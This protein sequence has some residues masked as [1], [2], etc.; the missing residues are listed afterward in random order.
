MLRKKNRI[1]KPIQICKQ[2]T[3]SIITAF[4]MNHCIEVTHVLQIGK[5]CIKRALV[6]NFAKHIM[7]FIIIICFFTLKNRKI[8]VRT[9][10]V[11]PCINIR[12][13]FLKRF[14]IN[15][16]IYCSFIGKSRG[17]QLFYNRLCFFS[18]FRNFVLFLAAS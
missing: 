10:Y 5:F 8:Y 11:K 14:K 2:S 9:R 16:S 1:R 15:N 4:S 18:F 17:G 3:F 7:T 12:V 6:S 13:F